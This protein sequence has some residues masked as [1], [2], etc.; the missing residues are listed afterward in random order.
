M[1]S[2]H[3]IRIA[4]Y[5]TFCFFTFFIGRWSATPDLDDFKRDLSAK[6]ITLDAQKSN[7]AIPQDRSTPGIARAKNPVAN[8]NLRINKPLQLNSKQAQEDIGVHNIEHMGIPQND[9]ATLAHQEIEIEALKRE[10]ADSFRDSGLPEEDINALLQGLFPAAEAA[11]PE[12]HA[13][14]D[15]SPEQVAEEMEIS[16]LEAGVPQE[17]IDEIMRGFM[18]AIQPPEEFQVPP[19][20]P[21]NLN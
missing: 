2:K 18:T 13:A 19:T 10:F 9:P 12:L 16:L 4:A 21:L 15:L 7:S 1:K 14:S 5:I 8:H 11:T 3:F 6:G 20:P 17:D